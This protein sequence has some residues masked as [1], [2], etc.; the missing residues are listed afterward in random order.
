[1]T[2]LAWLVPRHLRG[3]WLSLVP[4]AAVIVL[5]GAGALLAVETA[6][7][8][9]TAYS[10][11]LD[12]ADVGDLVINP[13]LATTQIDQ[14]IRSLPG[15][16]EVTTDSLFLAGIGAYT[17]PFRYSEIPATSESVRGSFDG[18]RT[19]M[20]RLAYRD[21]RAATGRN[22]AVVSVD[23]ADA[24]GLEVGDVLPITFLPVRA[25]IRANF[26]GEDPLVTPLGVERLRIVGI[27]TFPDEVL[28]DGLY[29][30]G[31]V[32]VS[33]DVAARYDCLPAEPAPDAAFEAAADELTPERCSTS[34]RYWSLDIDGG[35]D[36]VAAAQEAFIQAS[37]ARRNDLPPSLLA[38]DVGY[39]M[40]ATDTAQYRERVSVSVR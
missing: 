38:R 19:T 32:V 16:R 17:A 18:R 12:R 11:Y 5:G 9:A 37:S 25:D 14:V 15:V 36:A 31:T 26:F 7:R 29:P 40:I 21:G 30:R 1:V 23:L 24:Q 6:Q 3:R 39:I 34:Y 22:E 8:T 10:R 2:V 20:D 4:V 33:P 13:S 27:A 28:P 35:D